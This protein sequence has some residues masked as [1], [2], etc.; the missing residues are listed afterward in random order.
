M[1]YAILHMLCLAASKSQTCTCKR[2]C[3]SEQ[4]EHDEGLV[5]VACAGHANS[6][7]AFRDLSASTLFCPRSSAKLHIDDVS[8]RHVNRSFSRRFVY[9]DGILPVKERPH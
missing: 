8:T 6:L 9:V 1:F 4:A 3:K 2:S 5:A 7:I